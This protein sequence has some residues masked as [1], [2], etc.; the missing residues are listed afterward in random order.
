VRGRQGLT[1]MVEVVAGSSGTDR[2]QAVLVVRLVR[3]RV[4][5]GLG[6]E[7]Q[8]GG[9]LLSLQ[10]LELEPRNQMKGG[11]I[12]SVKGWHGFV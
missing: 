5:P 12:Q 4:V 1:W 8:T 9:P 6:V 11:L 10:G 3:D 2:R 7:F